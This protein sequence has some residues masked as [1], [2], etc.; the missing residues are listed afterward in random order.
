MR[1]ARNV[2][3]KLEEIRSTKEGR[4]AVIHSS[5]S[6]ADSVPKNWPVPYYGRFR[7]RGRFGLYRDYKVLN[8]HG[9]GEELFNI[10]KGRIEQYNQS[11]RMQIAASLPFGLI[12]A[13]PQINIKQSLTMKLLEN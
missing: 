13:T 11:Y 2:T 3:Y 1:I 9:Q 7:V 12:D 6:L 8:L 4:I 10:D 5:Y